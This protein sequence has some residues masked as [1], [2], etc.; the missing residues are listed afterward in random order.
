VQH[1]GVGVVDLARTVAVVLAV[2]LVVVLVVVVLVVLVLVLVLVDVVVVLVVGCPRLGR[3]VVDERRSRWSRR[4][5]RGRAARHAAERGG[6]LA[7]RPGARR[8]VLGHGLLDGPAQRVG[9]ARRAQ[10]GDGVA[11]H[12]AHRGGECVGVAADRERRPPREQLEQR[13]AEGV[14]VGRG[15]RA[16]TAQHLRRGVHDAGRDGPR[17]GLGPARHPGDPEVAELGLA[18]RR[19]EDV[20]RLHVA[21]EHAH[22]VRGVEGVGHAGPD[23]GDLG[24][25]HRAAPHAVGQRAVG[26]EVHDEVRL[27]G[28]GRAGVVDGDDVG[29]RRQLGDGPALPLEPVAGEVVERA[30]E[31]LDGDVAV[32]RPLAGPVDDREAAAA[33]LLEQLVAGDGIGRAGLHRRRW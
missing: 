12:P 23:R 6:Q 25:R 27:A 24:P 8:G 20:R 16:L 10:V 33:D 18:P 26:Q 3:A 13:R 22:P 5:Q 11:D 19:D 2:V 7:G 29:V 17:L 15:R 9:D 4:G 30:R 28:R 14:D 21:V 1:A 31:D 32:E